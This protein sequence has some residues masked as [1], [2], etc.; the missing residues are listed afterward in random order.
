M[1]YVQ[2]F[3][4]ELTRLPLLEKLYLDNNKLSVLP[5]E[6]GELKHLKVLAVDYNMLVSVPGKCWI[7]FLVIFSF[8]SGELMLV[9]STTNQDDVKQFI[10]CDTRNLISIQFIVWMQAVELRQCA[11]LLELSLEQNKL[12][13]PILDFRSIFPPVAFF[14]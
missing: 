4:V 7:L 2:A 11:G 12:V 13:R 6:V 14:A 9:T 3:P 8:L 10:L 1:Y 5:P